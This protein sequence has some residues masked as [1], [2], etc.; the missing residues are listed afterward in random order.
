MNLSRIHR[1]LTLIGLL[2]A[3]REH[4]IDAIARACKVHRRTVFRDL[5]TLREAGVP[6]EFDA[7]NQ[8]YAIPGTYYLPPTDFTPAEALTLIVLCHE[9]GDRSRLPFFEP[10]GSACVK[11]ES[12]LPSN[13][14]E[15]VRRVAGTIQ[16]Q[17]TPHSQ[18]EG[19]APIYQQLLDAVGRRQC[20]RIGY[21]SL[22][23][24]EAI[25]TRLEIYRLLFSRR[26]WYAI[27]RS[28]LHRSVRTFNVGRIQHC[29]PVDE[30]YQIP[31]NFS[32]DR[33]LRNAWH[34]IPES[35]PDHEVLVR[36]HP[37]VAQNVAEILW[38]KTQRTRILPDGSLE[39]AATVSG[40]KE[41]SWWILGYGEQAEV[42]RPEPLRQII[43]RHAAALHARYN[44]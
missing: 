28:S 9:M 30:S 14:R 21:D 19:K 3:G 35:G 20:V 42:I 26:S 5:E 11:L 40:L 13:L 1:L 12:A 23:E 34:M 38:H 2:Q 43:G 36:F 10:V 44:G 4:S 8:R 15:W 18:V 24:R 41:I 31:Q 7:E 22:T 29:E 33:Y 6:L 39:F 37:M 17:P 25:S 32:V 27:G 16:I